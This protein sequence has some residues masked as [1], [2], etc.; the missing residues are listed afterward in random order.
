MMS[1]PT[2]EEGDDRLSSSYC[3]HERKG[4]HGLQVPACQIYQ[5]LALLLAK[6]EDR[7]EA[8]PHGRSHGQPTC[9]ITSRSCYWTVTGLHAKMI[10]VLGGLE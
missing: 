7:F 5:V 9:F 8:S 6:S 10:S 3:E 4:F 2:G 1:R